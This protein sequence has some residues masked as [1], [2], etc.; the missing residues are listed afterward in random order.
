MNTFRRAG[1]V[2][3]ALAL[4]FAGPVAGDGARRAVEVSQAAL[5]N[6]LPDIVLT[7]A[8]GARHALHDFRGRPL[9][10]SLIF[11]SCAHSCSVSTRYLGRMVDVAR[12]ALGADAF[13]VLTI[14][15]DV[16]VDT[17][18]TM[19]A[20]AR[21][22]SINDPRWHFMSS[23]DPSAM[24]ALVEAL[25]FHYE[26]SPRGFDHTVKATIVDRDGVV[27][28]HVY[29]ETFQ[30]PLL[31]EPLKALVLG[32]P[33]PEDGFLARLENRVRLFCTV[34]DARA[35]R[36]YFDYSLFAGIFIGVAF[37]GG[38]MSWMAYEFWFRRR[39]RAA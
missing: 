29:G 14:G 2:A 24:S 28:R 12:D 39:R 5:G 22:H 4:A 25:G 10:V 13:T 3:A 38:V 23:D 37:L 17:P 36:Y 27:H 15:F 30:V 34:Y 20:Y 19:Q 26:A 35:D 1:A 6:T 16:G 11:T 33:L 21:R 7:D 32:R 31:V 9:L 18:A 8:S